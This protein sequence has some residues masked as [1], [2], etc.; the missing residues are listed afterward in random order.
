MTFNLKL[1]KKRTDKKKNKS[2]LVVV[3]RKGKKRDTDWISI[4]GKYDPLHNELLINK[5][6]LSYWLFR[7]C[8]FSNGLNRLVVKINKIIDRK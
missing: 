2:Y 5:K 8:T 1:A 3:S 7:G 4:L 6:R